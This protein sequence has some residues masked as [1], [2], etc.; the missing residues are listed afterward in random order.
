MSNPISSVDLLRSTAYITSLA[1]RVALDSND[2]AV[3]E[4]AL[5]LSPVVRELKQLV[6]GPTENAAPA[7]AASTVNAPDFQAL[8]NVAGQKFEKTPDAPAASLRS[9]SMDRI[10]VALSMAQGGA[11]GIEIAKSLGLT[12]A[13]VDLILSIA[14]QK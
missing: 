7:P 11:N 9:D 12:R 13:E 14:S 5:K 6:D 2:P 1:R 10:G 8:V 3:R 4:K